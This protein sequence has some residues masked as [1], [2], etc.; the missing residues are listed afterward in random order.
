MKPIPRLHAS[1]YRKAAFPLIDVE[2]KRKAPSLSWWEL[3][4]SADA[5]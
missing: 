1:L 4:F 2:M 3:S 5:A